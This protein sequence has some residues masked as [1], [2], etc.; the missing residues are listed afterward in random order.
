MEQEKTMIGEGEDTRSFDESVM[1][2]VEAMKIDSRSID[3][4]VRTAKTCIESNVN[5]QDP[6]PQL[7]LTVIDGLKSELRRKNNLIDA[8]REEMEG[9]L[10]ILEK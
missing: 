6:K 9:L 8:R 1:N 5:R 3:I 7:I 2:S 4:L 10:A